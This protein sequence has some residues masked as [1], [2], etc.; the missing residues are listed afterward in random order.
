MIGHQQLDSRCGKCIE[1]R[2]C[3]VGVSES[4]YRPRCMYI[5]A[6]FLTVAAI[7]KSCNDELASYCGWVRLTGNDRK[8]AELSSSSTTYNHRVLGKSGCQVL[9]GVSKS[10]ERW[11]LKNLVVLDH[12]H[13]QGSSCLMIMLMGSESI[14]VSGATILLEPY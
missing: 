14:E 2:S 8:S 5:P 11:T 1:A 4:F 10:V 3:N 9:E 13:C 12:N 7:L 6:T